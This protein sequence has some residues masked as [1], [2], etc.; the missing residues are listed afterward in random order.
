MRFIILSFLF[1]C[2]CQQAPTKAI[3]ETVNPL[4][5]DFV[6]LDTRTA[7]EFESFSVSGSAHIWWEDFLVRSEG[8]QKKSS[9]KYRID[10]LEKIIERLA[11]RGVSPTKVIILVGA[12]ADAIE[13]LKWNWLLKSLEIRN[14]KML[15]LDQAKSQFAGRRGRPE[16]QSPWKL[17]QSEDFQNEFIL[18]YSQSC[19]IKFSAQDC[20]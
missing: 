17:S 4:K 2:S 18:S 9:S 1:L 11:S 6:L 15:S 8:V 14:I 3:T 13:N 20:R 10:N 5:Q 19:F 7:L 16:S 12:R